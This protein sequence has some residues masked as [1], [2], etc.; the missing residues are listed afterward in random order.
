MTTS[1]ITSPASPV[2]RAIDVTT[3]D[4]LAEHPFATDADITSSVAAA[5]HAFT[6]WRNVPVADRAAVVRRIA[7]LFDERVDELAHIIT[8]EMGKPLTEA[9]DEV[10]FSAAIFRYNADHAEEHLADQLLDDAEDSTS[11][12]QKLPVGV[13]LGVMPWNYPYYQIARFAAP[14]LLVGNTVLL[15]HAESVP[16]SALATEEIIRKALTEA[17]FPPAGYTN[18]FATHKQ[19]S[20]VITDP[21]VQGVSLTGSERAGAA[22][23]S[24]AGAALKKAVLELG[25]SDPYVVLS[26][27]D[28]RAQARAALSQRLENTGQVCNGN[29]R[30]IVMDDI[31]DAFVDEI[32]TRAA[33][34]TPADPRL[35][36]T[37]SVAS[38]DSASPTFG[39]LSSFPAADRLTDQIDRAVAAGATLLVGG[40]RVTDGGFASGAYVYP[41]VL[42]DVPVGS[43]I[44]Y[45]EMFGPVVQI[46]RVTSDEE[47]LELANNTR[48]G[49]GST[50]FAVE[51]GRAEAFATKVEA[52]MTG[53]NMTP[54]EVDYL[55]FGGV[56]CSGY[57]RELGVVGMDEFVNKRLYSV[58]K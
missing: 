34:Y 38:A 24:Q 35:E 28:P 2:Y 8:G 3:G 21:R 22:I 45:E 53:A 52:G 14:N 6:V 32:A 9:R 27:E 55:P 15:K 25:G 49:L 47:A 37:G 7:D 18:L 54:P 26:S 57:G 39:P 41:T 31:Y 12:Y 4:V 33:E 36:T 16:T 29:K 44:Y 43:D 20:S 58:K 30:L 42:T 56:K 19:I 50:V 11:W 51:E 17:G 48:F 10:E 1:T 40:T 46:F 23:A 5:A 13:I